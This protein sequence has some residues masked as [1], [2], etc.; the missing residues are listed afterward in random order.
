MTSAF[1]S[2]PDLSY[3]IWYQF[4]TVVSPRIFEKYGSDA[5]ASDQSF[6]QDPTKLV[7]GSALDTMSMKTMRLN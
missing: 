4:V 3:L 2:V 1:C 7:E 5:P 6:G